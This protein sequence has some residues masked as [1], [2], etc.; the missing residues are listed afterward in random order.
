MMVQ[1][2]DGT[3]GEAIVPEGAK[4][5]QTLNL[6]LKNTDQGD[7]LVTLVRPTPET[8]LGLTFGEFRGQVVIHQVFPGYPAESLRAGDFVH[9]VNGVPVTAE[10]AA[11]DL[12]SKTG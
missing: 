9:A 2:P 12:A 4:A 10:A 11:T 6:K 5:G 3:L 1:T 8:K 7:E